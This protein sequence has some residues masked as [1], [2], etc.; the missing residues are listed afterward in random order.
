MNWSDLERT[1]HACYNCKHLKERKRY[2]VFLA[3]CLLHSSSVTGLQTFFASDPVWKDVYEGMP[4]L[5]EQATRA[6]F[7]KGA[8]WDERVKLIKDHLTL[9]RQ[10][11]TDDFLRRIYYDH[12]TVT[13]WRDEFQDKPLTMEILFHPG[14]RKEGCLSLVLRWGEIDFYQIMFWLSPAPDTGKPCIFVGALQGT[15]LGND[16][17]KAMTKKFFGY[18]TKNL[19]FYGLRTLADLMGCEKIYAV[20]NE[21]YYAMNH[22]RMDRKLKTNF[23]DFWAECGGTPDKDPR[24]YVIPLEERRR[25]LSELK[26]SKRANHRRRYA[27]M[28]DMRAAMAEAL[29]PWKRA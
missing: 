12:E 4:C 14:Q 29:R 5:L 18:R 10:T 26:P 20:T 19:I 24:F 21:G 28:D 23:G 27:L 11:M 8:Q 1:G 9:L 13:L 22:V 16:A 25:D 17:V 2:I 15:T 3:R 6:F 7:Y